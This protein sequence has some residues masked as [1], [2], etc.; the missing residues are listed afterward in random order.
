[1]C[2]VWGLLTIDKNFNVDNDKLY[3]LFMTIK[4][5]GIKLFKIVLMIKFQM[6]I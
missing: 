2:G 4:N 6:N 1:M 3:K 5:H